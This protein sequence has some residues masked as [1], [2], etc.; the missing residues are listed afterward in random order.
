MSGLGGG[1]FTSAL[2][3]GDAVDRLIVSGGYTGNS[4]IKMAYV[5]GGRQMVS[6]A[7][8]GPHRTKGQEG[9]A[10]V[11]PL[12]SPLT[13]CPARVPPRPRPD[14]SPGSSGRCSRVATLCPP[15]SRSSPGRGP[16]PP[17]TIAPPSGRPPRQALRRRFC[18]RGRCRAAVH[19]PWWPSV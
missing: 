18:R 3:V 6:P 12:W 1:G 4:S 9:R 5:G 11:R 19:T 17:T 16:V 13:P 8:S 10:G 2:K 15:I 7:I 14:A